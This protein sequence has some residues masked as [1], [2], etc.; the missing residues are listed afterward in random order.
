[1]SVHEE[2]AWYDG[3][4]PYLYTE[5]GPHNE[6]PGGIIRHA[7]EPTVANSVL[8]AASPCPACGQL[9]ACYII[10][11]ESGVSP[12]WLREQ[13]DLAHRYETHG[14]RIPSRWDARRGGWFATTDCQ[15][16]S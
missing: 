1:M 2:Q 8:T 3:K 16:P 4:L 14:P 13:A 6:C 10:G 9:W 12:D 11:P 15:E 7:N 5:C